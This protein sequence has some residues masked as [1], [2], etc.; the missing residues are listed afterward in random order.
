MVYNFKKPH[1]F[2]TSKYYFI[3]VVFIVKIIHLGINRNVG[4]QKRVHEQMC[5]FQAP[6]M[7]KVCGYRRFSL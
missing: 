7:Y 3:F 1:Q 2:L 5:I 6:A 4:K